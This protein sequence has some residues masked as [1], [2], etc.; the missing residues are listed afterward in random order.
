M[1]WRCVTMAACDAEFRFSCTP[2]CC[3]ALNKNKLCVRGGIQNIQDWRRH[4]DIRC[5]SAKHRS[6]QAK[7]WIHGSTATSCGDWVKTCEDI[8]P[9]FGENKPGCFTMTTPRLTL[10]SSPKQFLAK[11]EM[12]FIPHPPYSLDLAPCD[13]FL[14]PKM[15]F[16]L[17]GRRFDTTEEIQAKSQS[18]W[19][20][21]RKG[22]PGSVRKM[23]ET[24]WPVSTGGRELLRGLWRPIGLMVS[25]MIW[26]AS[27]Q[28]IFITPS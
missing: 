23:E 3:Y 20:S 8:A 13:F 6:Q 21:Y 7:L 22:L 15:K 24:V 1:W 4:L 10:P 2:H 12:A 25:F 5:G 11:C 18:A 19:H 26:I 16:K 9:N 27:V 28:I 14:F 17:E